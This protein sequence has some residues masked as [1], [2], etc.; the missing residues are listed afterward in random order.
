[1]TPLI[2]ALSAG[3]L[4]I[5]NF[6]QGMVG[7]GLGMVSVPILS[8]FL[9]VKMAIPIATVFGWLITIPVCLKMRQHINFKLAFILYLPAIV[10]GST[11]INR[12]IRVKNNIFSAVICGLLSV[13]KYPFSRKRCEYCNTAKSRHQSCTSSWNL[14]HY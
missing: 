8:L 10:G 4:F 13:G 5:G 3:T 11:L 2:I 14:G 9:D 7:F 12:P 6:V 1:M